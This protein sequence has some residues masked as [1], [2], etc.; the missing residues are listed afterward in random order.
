MIDANLTTEKQYGTHKG[1]VHY[2]LYHKGTVWAAFADWKIRVWNSKLQIQSNSEAAKSKILSGHNSAVTCMVVVDEETVWSCAGTR[3]I[4]WNATTFEHRGSA[5]E[6]KIKN[7]NFTCLAKVNNYVWAGGSNVD[8]QF[9]SIVVYTANVCILA[10]GY[11]LHPASFF[12][13]FLFSIS[14]QSFFD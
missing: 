3:I 12:L 8:S 6:T 9:P 5:I 2:L 7:M 1:T 4:R 13:P 11:P 10:P 14:F